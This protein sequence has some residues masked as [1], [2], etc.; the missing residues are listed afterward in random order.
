LLIVTYL[1][2]F[3]KYTAFYLYFYLFGK[4]IISKI[5]KFTK[6]ERSKEL[7]FTK[8]EYLA[9][10]F[11]LLILGNLLIILNIF[12]PLNNIY[13]NIFLILLPF[14]SL[15]KF[16]ID[17]KKYLNTNFIFNYL[18]IP[19]IL[20]IST[21][22]ITFNYDAGYY[23]LLHQNWIRESEVIVGMVNI[24]FALGM[25]SIYEYLSAILWF[26]SSF[27]YLHF[28]NIYFLHFFYLFIKQHFLN[29]KYTDL[30][31]V[32]FVILIYSILDNFGFGG[33]RNGYAYI[34]GVTKQ[35]TTVGILFWFLSI[36]ILKKIKEKNISNS[37]IVTI[38]LISF[39]VYQIK[40]SGVLVFI[41]YFILIIYIL[42]LKLVNFTRLIYLHTP[43]IL[44]AVIWFGKSLLTTGCFI[45]PVDF[46]CI[47]IFD[48]YVIG[49]TAEVE[50][51]TK[52]ASKNYTLQTPFTE[53][54]RVVAKD[55]FEYRGQVLKNF[56]AS[57]LI[58]FV[59]KYFLFLKQKIKFNIFLISILFLIFNFT[60]LLF[61]GPIP[62]YTIG[63]C[64]VSV[65]LIGFFAGKSRYEINDYFK[66]F[67]IFISIFLIVRLHSYESLVFNDE[68]RLFDPRTSPEVYEKV[69]FSDSFGNW[70]RPNDG[71]QCWANLEC[72]MSDEDVIFIEKGLFKYAYRK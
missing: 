38:S 2:I 66:Y 22:D 32:A 12:T 68:I 49:S 25:S 5:F 72:T 61:Y 27:V 57:F 7:V 33:G 55:T 58:I 67:L 46:T 9:P 59:L 24:F 56:T 10:F 26:D 16:R 14:L 71:D 30:Y 63:V 48:W 37:E 39:F 41:L 13:V 1:S 20:V 42:K 31:N 60:Y 21:V 50:Y 53:W 45:Y 11:G 29:K 15:K 6:E 62:R 18:V 17:I 44:I 69:G 54:I 51:Y 35:D 47:E 64:L 23:H 3:I 40:V 4:F 34:Q 19:G 43:V 36:V 52:L 70:V 28:L 8:T 65:S